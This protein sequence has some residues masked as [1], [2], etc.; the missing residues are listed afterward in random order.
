MF[1]SL[2]RRKRTAPPT[3]SEEWI[4]AAAPEDS[5]TSTYAM[6][7]VE[8]KAHASPARSPKFLDELTSSP[9]S[10]SLELSGNQDPRENDNSELWVSVES[11]G[12]S[13]C[14]R[15]AADRMKREEAGPSTLGIMIDVTGDSLVQAMGR[16]ALDGVPTLLRTLE[17]LARLH[18]FV[19]LAFIPFKLLYHLEVKRR[20]NDQRRAAL[21][22]VIKDAM[23]ALVELEY[24]ADDYTA[25]RTTPA[26]Q[27]I[28]SR[29]V[30]VCEQMQKDIRG[31]YEELVVHDRSAPAI[32]F[33]RA[34]GRNKVLA[35]YGARFKAT[36]EDLVFALQI[37]NAVAVN[38]MRHML[39]E[40]L[41]PKSLP[42]ASTLAPTPPSSPDGKQADLPH[43]GGDQTEQRAPPHQ[44]PVPQHDASQICLEAEWR[45]QAIM[46]PTSTE[47]IGQIPTG[48]QSSPS[49][50]ISFSGKAVG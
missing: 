31:C 25:Y 8:D 36:R 39:E 16:R 12:T 3:T 20:D 41:A 49:A 2:R 34:S 50:N 14:L 9:K 47:C 18:P 23:L 22:G 48:K 33:V 32:H 10:E 24:F 30:G 4:L 44:F 40:Q 28:K 13:Y 35:D 27:K 15:D 42:S 26:G 29:I 43:K 5:S 37:E 38:K 46:D 21:F 11:Y 19:E 6:S 1:I 17:A 45:L 7:A